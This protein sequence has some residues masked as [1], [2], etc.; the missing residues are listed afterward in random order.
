M[1]SPQFSHARRPRRALRSSGRSPT[2]RRH[3]VLRCRFRRNR[4][5]NR[6]RRK[7][8]RRARWAQ[9]R[10]SRGR[11]PH[12]RL[13][14]ASNAQPNRQLPHPSTL[15]FQSITSKFERRLHRNDGA[16][17]RFDPALRSTTSSSGEVDE[18]LPRSRRRQRRPEI[19][20]DDGPHQR[21]PEHDPRNVAGHHRDVARLGDDRK[22]RASTSQPVYVLRQPEPGPSQSRPSF[23]ECTR[24]ST[25]QSAACR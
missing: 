4:E 20:A 1:R 14:G 2:Q 21:R 16:R 17:R 24:E 23:R 3:R 5:V 7:L 19:A 25:R 12:S 8:R 13:N 15:R 9:Q 18:R 11:V 6:S 22:R 10:T